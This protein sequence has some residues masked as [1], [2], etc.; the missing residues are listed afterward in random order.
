MEKKIMINAAEIAE[1]LEVSKAY[2]YN[3][4]KRLNTELEKMGFITVARKVSRR[5]Y[6]EKLYGMAANSVKGA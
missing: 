2:A 5:Y 4:I 1:D 6:E 3:L